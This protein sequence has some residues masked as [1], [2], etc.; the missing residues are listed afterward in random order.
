VEAGMPIGPYQ[1]RLTPSGN[2]QTLTDSQY[3]TGLKP[4][5]EEERGAG[6][7]KL[8]RAARE[9]YRSWILHKQ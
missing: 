5:R 8:I 3:A 4:A 7:N 1:L 9:F 2:Q 6:A